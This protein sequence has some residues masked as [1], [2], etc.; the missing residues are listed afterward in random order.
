MNEVLDR[1]IE[2]TED[3]PRGGVWC[4]GLC[5]MSVQHWLFDREA[6]ASTALRLALLWAQGADVTRER[7]RRAASAVETDAT[8]GFGVNADADAA[9]EAAGQVGLALVDGGAGYFAARLAYAAAVRASMGTVR[10]PDTAWFE[11]RER[12]AG[13]LARLVADQLEPVSSHATPH[14]LWDW[15]LERAPRRHRVGTL[16][17]ALARARLW[18]LRWW[19]PSE[20][21]A[22]ERLTELPVWWTGRASSQ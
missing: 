14:P 13:S 4:A 6:R 17:D 20:R 5:A 1:L 10:A 8:V 22:A 18:H 12:H 21:G 19:V 2:L 7:L 11:A 9:V 3:D 16:G 15:T